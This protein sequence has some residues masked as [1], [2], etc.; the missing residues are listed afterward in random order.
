MEHKHCLKYENVHKLWLGYHFTIIKFHVFSRKLQ[1]TSHSL[2][3]MLK[4]TLQ[5][6]AETP[7]TGLSKN[8]G[9]RLRPTWGPGWPASG[10]TTDPPYLPLI[11][12]WK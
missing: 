12:L 1:S 10:K 3:S 2:F 4:T 9:L 7:I 5:V 8:Y 6:A 11:L